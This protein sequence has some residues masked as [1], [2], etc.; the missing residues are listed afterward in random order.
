MEPA[1]RRRKRGGFLIKPTGVR[2][3]ASAQ[4]GTK[5]K[6]PTSLRKPHTVVPVRPKDEPTGTGVTK[7]G[8]RRT[9]RAGIN[10]SPTAQF[11]WQRDR[12]LRQYLP[13]HILS[14]SSCEQ[15]MLFHSCG[16]LQYRLRG[17]AGIAG[18]LRLKPEASHPD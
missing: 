13:Q 16:L 9:G 15:L 18:V 1:E 3:W 12:W 4:T 17:R 6:T 2:T 10:V 5:T 14:A 11:Q 7:R 8:K